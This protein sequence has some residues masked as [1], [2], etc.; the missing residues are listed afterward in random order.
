ME[1]IIL[2]DLYYNHSCRTSS[3]KN[4]IIDKTSK[5]NAKE[6]QIR[7]FQ[8]LRVSLLFSLKTQITQLHI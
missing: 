2:R 4:K 5:V 8:S 7:D 3:V 6:A 1:M